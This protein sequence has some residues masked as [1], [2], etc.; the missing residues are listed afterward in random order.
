[1]SVNMKKFIF[2]FLELLVYLVVVSCTSKQEKLV[3]S[4]FDKISGLW[5]IESFLTI[6]I[7]PTNLDGYI[8]SGKLLFKPCKY[9]KKQFKDETSTCSVEM[10][11]NNVLLLSRFRYDY[12]NRLFYINS[13]G[14]SISPSPAQEVVAQKTSQLIAGSWELTVVDDKLFGKQK[15][16]QNGVKGEI[17][18]VAVRR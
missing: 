5:Q 17:S 4:E 18:F 15:Q 10:E 1:M 2:P 16:N 9:D 12:S 13:L 3:Q 8:K 6:G 11:L 7:S 14:F